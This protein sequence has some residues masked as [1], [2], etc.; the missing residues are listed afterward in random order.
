M[1]HSFCLLVN[2]LHL[3]SGNL[4]ATTDQIQVGTLDLEVQV[5]M[6]PVSNLLRQLVPRQHSFCACFCLT[7]FSQE[8]TES[9]RPRKVK[10]EP[11]ETIS[12]SVRCPLNFDI[13]AE[14]SCS[15]WTAIN[16]PANFPWLLIKRNNEIR[17]LDKITMSFTNR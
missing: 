2:C 7:P 17:T 8:H 5:A 15:K 9:T 14:I 13:L 10:A 16:V 1:K 6:F 11:W 3:N 12:H 4:L